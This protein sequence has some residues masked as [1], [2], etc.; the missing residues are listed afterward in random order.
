MQEVWKDIKGFE[1]IYQISNFGNVRSL[2]RRVVNHK[3]GAT[4]IVPGMILSPWDNGNG[5]LVVSLN[6]KR[7]R[8]NFYVHRIVAEHFIDNPENK[9]CV[10]H[11]DYNKY[12]N[13]VSNLEWC[14][15]IEN[16]SHSIDNMRRH[17]KQC[18][19]TNTGEKYISKS[20]KRQKYD[21]YRVAIKKLG[22]DR[23]FKTLEEAISYRNG[24]ISSG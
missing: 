7:K 23:Q 13:C 9:P 2:D 19:P 10:N 6:D 16:V 11:L 21:V 12:N 24:V 1:G 3:N 18:K 20:T 4:R 8:K 15:Q 5:Y 22:I 17:R 14:T